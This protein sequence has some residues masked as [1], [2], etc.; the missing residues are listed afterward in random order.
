MY[1]SIERNVKIIHLF[2]NVRRKVQ[3]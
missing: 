1:Y 3:P 2:S